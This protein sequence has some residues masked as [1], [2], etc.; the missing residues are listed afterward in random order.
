MQEPLPRGEL[1][2][3]R[4]ML[5]LC[6]WRWRGLGWEQ[7]THPAAWPQYDRE[8]GPPA[9][10][11]WEYLGKQ[12]LPVADMAVAALAPTVGSVLEPSRI[13]TGTLLRGRAGQS[14]LPT[15]T[16]ATPRALLSHCPAFGG[17]RAKA[18]SWEQGTSTAQGTPRPLQ[19]HPGRS[20]VSR[21]LR[22][23]Q[24]CLHP[25]AVLLLPAPNQ[26]LNNPKPVL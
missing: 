21:G 19:S 18:Q 3:G 20:V 26:T 11:L 9:G 16:L 12:D 14:P 6:P 1:D 4:D 10:S 15:T 13:L 7:G 23:T 2:V 8:L 5:R 17:S 22:G 24:M 25:P